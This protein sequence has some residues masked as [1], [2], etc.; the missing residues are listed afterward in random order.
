MSHGFLKSSNIPLLNN[1]LGLSKVMKISMKS[2]KIEDLIVFLWE[3]E[4][5]KAKIG[6]V[7]KQGILQKEG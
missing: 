3:D 7:T 6:F 1:A 4:E 2:R 5:R